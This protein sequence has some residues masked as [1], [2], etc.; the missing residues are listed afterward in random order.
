MDNIINEQAFQL[1]YEATKS[2]E[3]HQL[4]DDIMNQPHGSEGEKRVVAEKATFRAFLESY[5]SFKG[6]NHA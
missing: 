6:G 3:V 5:L 2:V 1:A 4:V